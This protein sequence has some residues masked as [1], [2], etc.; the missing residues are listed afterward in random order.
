MVLPLI[1]TSCSPP[2]RSL[3]GLLA[4]AAGRSKG[5]LPWPLPGA[6]SADL[7]PHKANRVAACGV[8][9][10]QACQLCRDLCAWHDYTTDADSHPNY[11]TT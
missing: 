3:L 4:S 5:R 2:G 8:T 7:N 9:L 11:S 1:F 6:V 10:P